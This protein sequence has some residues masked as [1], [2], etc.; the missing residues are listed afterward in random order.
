MVSQE[1]RKTSKNHKRLLKY[2]LIFSIP[3]LIFLTCIESGLMFIG[4]KIDYSNG[5]RNFFKSD[6]VLGWSNR[7]GQ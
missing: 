5:G 1:K 7:V 6:S 2:I 4:L 3:A